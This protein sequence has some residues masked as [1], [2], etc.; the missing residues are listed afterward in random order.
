MVDLNFKEKIAYRILISNN[1]L[2]NS[3]SIEIGSDLVNE[4]CFNV[5]KQNRNFMESIV[6]ENFINGYS[7]LSGKM[8]ELFNIVNFSKKNSMV[9]EQLKHDIMFQYISNNIG[10]V[11]KINEEYERK[12]VFHEVFIDKLDNKII[13]NEQIK[14]LIDSMVKNNSQNLFPIVIRDLKQAY[15]KDSD[16]TIYAANGFKAVI[17]NTINSFKEMNDEER[18]AINKFCGQII[19]Q[20]LNDH[21]N[22]EQLNSLAIDTQFIDTQYF[23]KESYISTVLSN[24][25]IGKDHLSML[26]AQQILN[27]NVKNLGQ[28]IDTLKS[29]FPNLDVHNLFETIGIKMYLVL[30]KQRAIEL[31]NGDYGPISLQKLE[32][33]FYDIDTKSYS[34]KE[35]NNEVQYTDSQKALINFLFASGKM[36][37][38][39][40]IRKFL[41]DEI[42]ENKLPLSRIIDEWELYYEMLGGKVSLPEIFKIEKSVKVQLKPDEKEIGP[43]VQLAGVKHKNDIST[44]YHE[45]EKRTFSTIPK[46]QGSFG[47]YEYEIL[48]LNDPSQMDVGYHTHCCFT[49]GGASQD[50]LIDGCTSK[51]SRI[52][53]IKSNGKVVAQSWVWRNGNTLCFDNIEVRGLSKLAGKILWGVYEKASNE[54]LIKSQ[55]CEEEDKKIRLVTIGK[56]YTDIGLNGQKLPSEQILLH[57]KKGIYTDAIEQVVVATS[58]DYQKPVSFDVEPKYQDSRKPIMVID[59]QSC[60]QQEMIVITEKVDKINYSI[61]SKTFKKTDLNRDYTF[62][63][64]GQ[65]WYIGITRNG[66]LVKQVHSYDD[67]S[68]DEIKQALQL[69]SEKM[70]TGELYDVVMDVNILEEN[71]SYGK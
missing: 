11:K 23:D 32:S 15:G 49:F 66:L 39:A 37:A 21:A 7:S 69:V 44:V 59:P 13:S 61:D 71:N 30:G 42:S 28:I 5:L 34:I 17:T 10:D 16:E 22:Y 40:N 70:K 53:T 55:E 33:M 41:S 35:K 62:L 18:N 2:E 57:P 36:D 1:K 20:Y 14:E 29:R 56:G 19:K 26:N 31:I 12:N 46:V 24:G 27:I 48:D 45:M 60:S 51:N 52:F 47:I 4:I 6:I 43:T 54:I 67:R 8:F 9:W 68:K 38:N 58:F 63:V 25:R 65:D 3:D 50:S 64:Y